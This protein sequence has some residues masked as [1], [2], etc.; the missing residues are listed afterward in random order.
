MAKKTISVIERR[1]QGPSV[2][3]TSSQP[4]PLVE[5]DR[6]EVRWTNT[7]ISPDHLWDRIHNKAWEYAVP[8]DIACPIDEIGG[9]VRDGRI[10]RGERGQEV[11]VKMLAKDYA[12]VVKQKTKETTAQTFGKKQLKDA[13]LS[14]AA[15]EHGDQAAEFLSKHTTLSVED[16]RGPSD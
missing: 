1:L 16:A 7:T 15:Q 3:R 12:R 9:L 14:G 10:V 13:I 4:I 2:F 11:L 6:W 8:E 5:G